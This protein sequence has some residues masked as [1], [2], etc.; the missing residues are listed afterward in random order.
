MAERDCKQCGRT[1]PTWNYPAVAWDDYTGTVN[2]RSRYCAACHSTRDIDELPDAG[3]MDDAACVGQTETMIPEGWEC[4]YCGGVKVK[5]SAAACRGCR[6][7][8]SP[9]CECG[10]RHPYGQPCAQC[11]HEHE[12]GNGGADLYARA[13]AVCAGCP[14]RSDCLEY[15]LD[16]V[17]NV[18]DQYGVWGGLDPA[19]RRKLRSKR[20]RVG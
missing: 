15:A 14:V 1:F 16:M 19:E 12:M 11:G 4:R 17:A 13:K 20:R 8:C 2:N 10:A 9:E 3:W 18:D 7:A 6:W 5:K